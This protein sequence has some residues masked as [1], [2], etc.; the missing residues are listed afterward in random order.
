MRGSC[1]RLF[2]F[3]PIMGCAARS[4]ACRYLLDGA[5][6]P[7]PTPSFASFVMSGLPARDGTAAFGRMNATGSLNMWASSCI[8]VPRL[9]RK[10]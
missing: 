1:F 4:R 5:K 10:L 6:L 3:G 7:G 8:V 2:S 9:R